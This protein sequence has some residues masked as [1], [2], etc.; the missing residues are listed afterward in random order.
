M[1]ILFIS[2]HYKHNVQGGGE[3]NLFMLCEALARRGHTI[4]V[5][6]SNYKNL[7]VAVENNVTVH[8]R[9]KTGDVH[10]IRGNIV[11]TFLFPHS[12]VKEIK[13]LMKKYVF[14]AIHL[15]GSSVAVAP[16]IRKMVAI[17]LFATVESYIS[18]CPKGDFVCGRTI[19]VQRWSSFTFV[20]CVLLSREIGKM[21]NQWF[22]RFNPVAW[23]FIYH[24]FMLLRSG[25]YS[26]RLFAVSNYVAQLLK[27]FYALPS[28]VLP[29]FVD[30]ASF[31]LAKKK[32][33]K[34]VVLYLGS[35]T[36]YKGVFVILD[37]VKSLNCQLKIVGEGNAHNALF[38]KIRFM[39]LDAQILSP[40]A[41]SQVP[42]FYASADVVVFPSL[43]PEPFGR[44]PLEAM[45]AKVPVVAS[46]TGGIQET[47]IHGK[48]GLL[49]PPGDTAAL[50]N[51]LQ[52]L[53]ADEPLRK[54]YGIAG[55]KFVKEFYSEKVVVDKL[56]NAYGDEL[57]G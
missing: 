50:R 48:T 18:L 38:N 54:K 24:R 55:N 39:H 33:K 23:L 20:R 27:T 7:H 31:K 5:L 22:I 9:L 11:R 13:T 57:H 42:S 16:A 44:I 21:K 25:L 8:Y 47:V 52:N 32:N 2:E 3:I 36:A 56:L 46:D 37:A 15:I 30:V 43:W 26:A 10:S 28:V 35:L 17:P 51:A 49:V 34:P 53:I 40:V 12:V 41:Y 45:A 14:D 4:H 19:L 29:N 6:T 1:N